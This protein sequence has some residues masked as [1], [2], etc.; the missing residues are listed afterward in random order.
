M[1]PPTATD[2]VPAAQSG[3]KEVQKG[4]P[5]FKFPKVSSRHRRELIERPGL[6]SDRGQP[7]ILCCDLSDVS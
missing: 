4:A 7:Y 1:S 2:N 3:A 6:A 5:K